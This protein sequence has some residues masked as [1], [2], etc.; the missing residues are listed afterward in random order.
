M[1]NLAEIFILSYFT[2]FI[3]IRVKI[4]SEDQDLLFKSNH[5]IENLSVFTHIIDCFMN[6][7]LIQN[8]ISNIITVKY[9]DSLKLIIKYN[10]EDCFLTEL[11]KL[12][13][14]TVSA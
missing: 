2:Q 10:K 3:E 9:R 1:I 8:D 4:L 11:D 13:I 5:L 12:S 14:M 7:I 6:Q